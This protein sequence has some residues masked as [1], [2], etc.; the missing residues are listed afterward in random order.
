LDPQRLDNVRDS[1]DNLLADGVPLAALQQVKDWLAVRQEAA[2]EL[3]RQHMRH[4]QITT[5]AGHS[6]G[7]GNCPDFICHHCGSPP[8]ADGDHSCPCPHRDEDCPDHTRPSAVANN[9][10][11]RG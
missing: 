1:L 6:Y 5:L 8:D 9:G 10:G 11:R 7:W 4:C 3:H 2:N